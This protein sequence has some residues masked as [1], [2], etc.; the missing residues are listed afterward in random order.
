MNGVERLLEC[1]DAGRLVRPAAQKLNFVDLVRALLRLAGA[2][3]IESAP[4][5][6]RIGRLIPPAD[7]YV[8]VLVD[9]LGMSILDKLAPDSFLAGHRAAQMQ[10][11]FPSTTACALTTLA[12]GAWPC[13]HGVPGWWVYL[14]EFKLSATALRFVERFAERP[15]EEFGLSAA[16][17]FGLP[18]VWPAVKH[19]PLSILGAHIVDSTFSRYARGDTARAGYREIPEAVRIVRDRV[20]QAQRPTFTYLYLPQLDAICH[21]K[22]VGH[23]QVSQLLA[24]LDEQLGNLAEALTGRAR[25][26]IT[27][28]HGLIDVPA[29]RRF[30]LE[31]DD[32]LVTHLICPP[33]GEPAVPI[34][35]VKSGQ[36]Q[37]F[38]ELFARRFG[39]VFVFITPDEAEGLRLFGPGELSPLMRR[40]LG[41]FIGIAPEPAAIY[42]RPRV[43][44]FHVHV[45][46]HAGMSAEEMNIP[47]VVL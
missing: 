22:G 28:D 2:G 6:E 10:A 16:D 29:E 1:F 39:D 17:V 25:I 31:E 23:E 43:G 44:D 20:E 32:P 27:A 38:L 37:A 4:G 26:V 24:S 19:A 5:V 12:T 21:K 33:T 15:L 34:F 40:R 18:S 35:H 14:E 45:A 36:E 41:N 47:L 30:I 8:F 9:G 42:F 7:H 13:E 46:V 3:G 11:L